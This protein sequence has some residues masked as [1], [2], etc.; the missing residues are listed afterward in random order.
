M[1]TPLKITALIA[2][3]LAIF[4]MPARHVIAEDDD[5][6]DAYTFKVHNTTDTKITG[7]LA[8]EDGESYAKFDIGKGLAPGETMTLKWDKSTNNTN[9]KWYIKAVFKDGSES[10]AKK[11]DFCEEDLELEF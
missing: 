10:K 1:K 11:F 8:S 4:V 3:A 5:D 6:D 7:L 2:F 9:C